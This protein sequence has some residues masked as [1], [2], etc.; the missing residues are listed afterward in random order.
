MD[1]MTARSWRCGLLAGAGLLAACAEP[2]VAAPAA[3]AQDLPAAP[4]PPAEVAEIRADARL[5]AEWRAYCDRIRGMAFIM[6]YPPPPGAERIMAD[7]RK[8]AELFPDAA[9]ARPR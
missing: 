9:D 1:R 2:P 8:C 3:G 6:I 5:T 7:Q 4:E